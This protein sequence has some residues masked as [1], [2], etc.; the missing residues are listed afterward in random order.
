[1]NAPAGFHLVNGKV[2]DVDPLRAMFNRALP[3][4]LL[5]MY[6]AGY[7]VAGFA[8]AGVYAWAWL[9]GKRDRYNRVALIVPLTIACLV[10]PVQVLVGDW[11]ARSVAQDQP[12]K[13]A[14]MEGLSRT[15]AGA[16]LHLGGLYRDGKVVD[17]LEIPR[18]L[19]LLAQHDPSATVTGL[20][21]VPP[22]QRPP[23]NVV[24]LSFQA[25][26]GIGTLLLLL[27]AAY[28]VTWWRRRRLPRSRWFFRAVVAAG[29]LSLIALWAG[30]IVTEVGRQP[31]IVYEVMRTSEAVTAAGGIRVALIVLV[32]VYV[33]LAVGTALVLPRLARDRPHRNRVEPIP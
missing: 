22:D 24:R 28:L 6:L 23:V 21:S 5:H 4:E 10:A 18:A 26:V 19:S 2:V 31:W 9:K 33:G 1:M 30:W 20:D 27:A 14:A 25:M 12:V 17:G 13:L 7:M 11:A 3:Y 15:Q 29:P 8:I 16:P 32:I